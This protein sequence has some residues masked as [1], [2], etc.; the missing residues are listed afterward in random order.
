MEVK[1][2]LSRGSP[3]LLGSQNTK[4]I[5]NIF[6]ALRIRDVYPG[7][8]FFSIPDPTKKRAGKK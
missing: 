2:T 5:A 8:G 1:R 3:S 4:T 6:T 7:S